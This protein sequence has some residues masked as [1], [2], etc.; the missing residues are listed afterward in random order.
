MSTLSNRLKHL[1]DRF[2]IGV[3]PRCRDLP[4]LAIRIL[5]REAVDAL[6]QAGPAICPECGRSEPERHVV[7]ITDRSD[8]PQ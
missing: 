8:G 2:G 4:R 6:E 3:C 5:D 1:E 7:I